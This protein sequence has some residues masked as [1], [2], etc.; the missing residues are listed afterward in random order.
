MHYWKIQPLR[1]SP[2]LRRRTIIS[3]AAKRSINA[4]LGRERVMF[5][6]V[7]FPAAYSFA[8]PKT[9]YGVLIDLLLE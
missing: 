4:E 5:V 2:T 6:K 9:H 8:A 7:A 1:T 3:A